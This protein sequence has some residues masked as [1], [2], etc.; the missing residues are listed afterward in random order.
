MIRSGKGC[1]K[2]KAVAEMADEITVRPARPSDANVIAV[3]MGQLGYRCVPRE[4]EARIVSLSQLPGDLI[5]VAERG[6]EVA[7]VLSLHMIPLFHAPGLAGRI[8]SLA[9]ADEHRSRGIGARLIGEAEAWAWSKGCTK[10]EVTSADRRLDAHRFYER[11]GYRIDERR[12]LKLK[13]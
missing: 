12:F 3:L 10:I 8:T 13:P 2:S 11:H 7:G 9:V 6:G 4:V 1:A 5:L